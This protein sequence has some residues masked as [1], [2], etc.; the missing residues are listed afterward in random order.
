MVPTRTQVLRQPPK[1]LAPISKFLMANKPTQKP[2]LLKPKELQERLKLPS[3]RNK[4][5]LPLSLQLLKPKPPLKQRPRKR[6]ESPKRR[7]PLP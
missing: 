3:K 2:L 7:R 1:L 6:E 4:P 5:D